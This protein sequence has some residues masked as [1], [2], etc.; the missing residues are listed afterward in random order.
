[1]LPLPFSASSST[2]F[3]LVSCWSS[4]SKPNLPLSLA[5]RLCQLPFW[6]AGS[7]SGSTSRGHRRATG[8]QGSSLFL[9]SPHQQFPRWVSPG[10]F[11]ISLMLLGRAPPQ[12][13][14][15]EL[16]KVEG[17]SS[18]LF[19]SQRGKFLSLGNFIILFFSSSPSRQL[20]ELIPNLIPL[21]WNI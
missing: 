19:P 18:N 3:P 17:P 6:T 8:S 11:R 2:T 14:E 7:L 1:M 16:Q 5:T 12:R 21:C 10:I 4:S 13:T 15:E 20:V 9:H